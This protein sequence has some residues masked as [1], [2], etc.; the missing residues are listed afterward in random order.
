VVMRVHFLILLGVVPLAGCDAILGISDRPVAE[1]GSGSGTS[2][3]SAA[4]GASG[5]GSGSGMA[6]GSGSSSGSTSGASGS[7]SG[8]SNAGPD[9]GLDAGPAGNEGGAVVSLQCGSD[10][11]ACVSGGVFS[12]GFPQDDAGAGLAVLP[13]GGTI[14]VTDDGFE[15]GGTTCDTTGMTCVTGAITP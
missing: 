14:T 9:G 15:F 4:S 5:E 10:A 6:S 3:G 12:I 2:S 11:G 8:S 13:D 1:Q 7:G